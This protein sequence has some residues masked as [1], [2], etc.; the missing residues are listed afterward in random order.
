MRSRHSWSGRDLKSAEID[1]VWVYEIRKMLT[2]GEHFL[3][4]LNL[5]LALDAL[6]CPARLHDKQMRLLTF[7]LSRALLAKDMLGN[8][9]YIVEDFSG[10]RVLVLFTT[11]LRNKTIIG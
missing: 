11:V 9:F 10:Y 1:S 8:L 4:F 3:C 2:D 6:V 5:L 7:F